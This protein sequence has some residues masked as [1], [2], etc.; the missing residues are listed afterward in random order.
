MPADQTFPKS[1]RVCHRAD[2]V[3]IQRK[4]LKFQTEHFLVFARAERPAP[5]VE[6][7]P[8]GAAEQ[9]KAARSESPRAVALS[10]GQPQA[11]SNPKKKRTPVARLGITTSRKSGNA[12]QRNK[13]RRLLREVFRQHKDLFTVAVDLVFVAKAEATQGNYAS[14]LQQMQAVSRWVQHWA[15]PHRKP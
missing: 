8:G 4:G 14:F 9:S 3:K 6:E 5:R 15:K 1:R 2:F 12:V 7:P 13:I 10:S 11:T